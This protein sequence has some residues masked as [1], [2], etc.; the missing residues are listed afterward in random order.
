MGV[1]KRFPFSSNLQRMSVIVSPLP[2]QKP[3]VY[4]KGAPE[5]IR[6][7]SNEETVPETFQDELKELTAEG[8]RVLALAWKPLEV[9]PLRADRLARQGN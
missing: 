4:V 9:R 6:C 7:L 8:Y 1:I 2:A 3:A 5:M